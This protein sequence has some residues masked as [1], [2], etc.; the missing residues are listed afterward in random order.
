MC[1][2]EKGAAESD[3]STNISTNLSAD[4]LYTTDPSIERHQEI[5]SNAIHK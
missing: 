3:V 2:Y 4:K 1:I 5:P